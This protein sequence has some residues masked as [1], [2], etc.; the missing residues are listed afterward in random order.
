MLKRFLPFLCCAVPA[1]AG[2]QVFSFDVN[3]GVIYSLNA[4]LNATT[5]DS[6]VFN[7]GAGVSIKGA[8]D[9]LHSVYVGTDA[10]DPV[11]I[12]YVYAMP[13]ETLYSITTTG[14]ITIGGSL[15]IATSNNLT[16]GG[17]SAAVG[18]NI[19]AIE[20]AGGLTISNAGAITLGQFVATGSGNVQINAASL[21]MQSSAFQVLDSKNVVVSLGGGVFNAAGRAVENQS[22][23]SLQITAGNFTSG[24]LVNGSTGGVLDLN[25]ASLTVTGG[26][27]TTNA[28]VVNKGTFIATVAG[29][30]N[31]AHGFDL[32]SMGANATFSLTTGT[33]VLGDRI[34]AF[35]SNNSKSRIV[36]VTAGGL[37]A[38]TFGIVNGTTNS[39]AIM[40][41]VA[42][43]DISAASITNYGDLQLTTNGNINLGGGIVS[44]GILNL[45]ALNINTTDITVSGGATYITGVLSDL[46]SFYAAGNLY[47]NA[48]SGVVANGAVN[49]QSAGYTLTSNTVSVAGIVQSNATDSMIIN[50]NDL[51]V[52]ANGIVGHDISV[53]NLNN[54]TGVDVT[55]SGGGVSGGVDFI[56]LRS[57]NIGGDYIFD[58]DSRLLAII[59][60]EADG[61]DYWATAHFYGDEPGDDPF[62][63]IINNSSSAEPL[64][65]ISGQLINN[66]DE[67]LPT[68]NNSPL[69]DSQIGIVLYQPVDQGSAIWLMHAN[70]GITNEFSNLNVSFCNADG[71]ICLNYLDAFDDM[72]DQG[73][74]LPIY[75]VT[76]DD[77]VYI[78][79]DD[80]FIRP[81][82]MFK[83]QPIVA[84]TNY[85]NGEYQSAGALDNLIEAQLNVNGFDYS[86][87]LTVV[88]TIFEGTV[89]D[90]MAEPLYEH[91]YD[92]AHSGHAQVI[93]RFSRLFQP[94]ELVQM[95]GALAMNTH[96]T[97]NDMADRF[98]DE[99][100]WNRNR[101][102]NKL[103]IDGNYTSFTQKI[104]DM[105]ADGERVSVALG[106]D[107]QAS[108]H[109]IWGWTGHASYSNNENVDDIDLSTRR[110]REFG[111]TETTV[112]N[113]SVGG[114]VYFLNLLSNKARWYGE[115]MF[116]MNSF[117]ITRHQTWFGEITGDTK[118]YS[119]TAE[120]GLIHDW[121]NQYIIGNLYL[122]GGYGFGFDMT[123][124]VWGR[125]YA[126]MKSDGYGMLTPGYS[127]T[128]QKRIYPS[129]WF[130]LRPYA[131]IGLEYDLLGVMDGTRYKYS[132]A[133]AW[134]D[135]DT[136]VDPLWASVGAGVEILSVTGIHVGIGYHY[137]YNP[138]VQ[139]H[140]IHLSGKYRF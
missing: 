46:T 31:L 15:N 13:S 25:L 108:K 132:N 48:A 63:V 44:G 55:V 5:T 24:T 23:G 120:F 40:Q 21:Y 128:A 97:F 19:G 50:T 123:E 92:Y 38:G 1:V 2:A 76:R 33:L 35:F 34:E 121:L 53:S 78:V 137:Q 14:A 68:P 65:S 82:G 42:L 47:Q 49:L 77:D 11:S 45:S 125:D 59:N 36:N 95:A 106:Y 37:D 101:R 116:D 73:E 26:D 87:P 27:S 127:L 56:G 67:T 86:A 84:K 104:E 107:W 72:N 18:M 69:L 130:E 119:V 39:D 58:E 62:G 9:V 135:Y 89:F 129:V 70:G 113:T 12:G 75:L 124:H 136:E 29:E 98:V 6:Y 81:A 88:H 41:L 66:L 96:F 133:I 3:P 16:I 4:P 52:G 51:M 109:W 30:T 20:A 114:G 139:A 7:G 99:V 10:P 90:V 131:T 54:P 111:R 122:R 103:W 79:F 110:V 105:K 71:T 93:E 80:R 85:T 32:E 74:G 64:I 118:T 140:K 17:V 91:M 134:T 57:M 61:Y 138:N 22:T 100:I 112:K 126:N 60:P 28:S 117:D 43:N 115:L 8:M 102:L 94:T 83:L